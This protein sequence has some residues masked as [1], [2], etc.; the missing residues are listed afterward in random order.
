MPWKMSERIF[1]TRD[2]RRRNLL[3]KQRLPVHLPKP[4]VAFH[5]LYT[6]DA[7]SPSTKSI[8][9]QFCQQSF[10]DIDSLI[11]GGVIVRELELVSLNL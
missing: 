5:L 6:T 10:D 2:V 4:R 3:T 9:W 1:T 7:C 8:V 11:R